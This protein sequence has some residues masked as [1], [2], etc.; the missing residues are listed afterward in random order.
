MSHM[1]VVNAPVGEPLFQSIPLS[2]ARLEKL[3]E[4]RHLP[5]TL[6]ERP[7]GLIPLF[8]IERFLRDVHKEVGENFNFRS[9]GMGH[10]S[11]SVVANIPLIHE[12]TE[13]Q[14]IRRFIGTINGAI[15]GAE[16]SVVLER[17]CVWLLRSTSVTEHS[18]A[19]AVVQYNLSVLFHG[20]CK[21]FGSD[22]R[23]VRLR[24][25]HA[26][27]FRLPQELA[28]AVPEVG[29]ENFGLGFRLTDIIAKRPT[30]ADRYVMGGSVLLAVAE[31]NRETLS[32]CLGTLLLGNSK[33]Q[34]AARMAAAF[35]MSTRS[36]QRKL[37]SL[38]TTHSGLLRD[39][40]IAL[41]TKM[42]SDPNVRITDLAFELGYTFPAD[43]TR[44]FK[45]QTGV[46]PVQYQRLAMADAPCSA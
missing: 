39:A 41:A 37:N 16:F 11:A 30:Q 3:L 24:L 34:K 36:Y 44:F 33:N 40:R 10:N 28:D 8:S 2:E 26:P 35:G 18:D 6:I 1:D 17:G 38:G 7:A 4:K 31:G 22:L 25:P 5:P 43:F 27:V 42:L 29:A 13:L 32:I 19:W 23:P 21:L 9:L 14:S 12:V 15:T 45:K 46:T 20:M